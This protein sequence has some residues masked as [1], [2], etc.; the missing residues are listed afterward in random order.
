[1]GAILSPIRMDTM[2]RG[3]TSM[4]TLDPMSMHIHTGIMAPIIT[5][6]D[7]EARRTKLPATC[8]LVH[9]CLI[10]FQGGDA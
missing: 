5:P 4:R 3:L 1:M 7:W 8:I 9:E 2:L 6:I 10:A